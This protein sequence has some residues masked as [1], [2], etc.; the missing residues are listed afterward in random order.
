MHHLHKHLADA[1]RILRGLPIPPE[2]HN[3]YLANERILIQELLDELQQHPVDT[4][5]VQRL[6]EKLAEEARD[7]SRLRTGVD[8]FLNEYSLSSD[9]GIV[10]MCLAE[11]LIRIPDDATAIRLIQDRLDDGDWQ[12]HLGQSDSM[13]VNASTWG[14][15]LTGRLFLNTDAAS[16]FSG[17]SRVASRLGKEIALKTIR[18]A[19]SIVGQQFVISE[20]I[21]DTLRTVGPYQPQDTGQGE[22]RYSFDM[23]G[24]AAL[25]E[26]DASGYLQSY[27]D[28]IE[29]LGSHYGDAPT[30]VAAISIKL[31]ALHPRFEPRHVDALRGV[32]VERVQVLLEAARALDIQV[33]VDAEEAHRHHLTLSVFHD[34]YTSPQMKGWD[35]LG[36]AVQTYQKRAPATLRWIAELAQRERRSIPVRLVKGAYWDTEVKRAQELGLSDYPVFVRKQATDVAYLACAH[37]ILQSD[38][39]LYGQFATHNAQTLASVIEFARHHE[40][41]QFEV[42]RL[43]GMGEVLCEV[44]REVHPQVSQRIYAPVGPYRELLPYLMRRLLENGANSSFVHHLND[45]RMPI[46]ELI[47]DPAQELEDGRYVSADVYPPATL[48]GP[49]RVNSA[50]INLDD[51]VTLSEVLEALESDLTPRQEIQSL[52]HAAV[53]DGDT[54]P[55]PIINPADTDHVLGHV[56]FAGATTVDS[57]MATATAAFDS[58]RQVGVGTRAGMLE[59]LANALEQERSLLLGLLTCEAGKTLTAAQAEIREAVDFCRYYAHLARE[60][61]GTPLQLPGPTGEQNT[62]HYEP[63]GPFLCIAPWNFPLAIFT[64]QLAAALVTGN[65]VIAKPSEFTGLIAS[66]LVQLA[67]RAGFPEQ[68]LSLLLAHGAD[69]LPL[70]TDSRLAGVSFTG[71]TATARTIQHALAERDGGFIP[72][73]AETG[74]LNA[75]I[76]DSSA[77]PEQVVR[78]VIESA[79]DCAGQRCSALRVLFVQEDIADAILDSLKGAMATLMVGHPAALDTDIGPVISAA[80]ATELEDYLNKFPSAS[81]MRSPLHDTAHG[82]YVAPAI[83]ELDEL[84]MPEREVFGPVLHV[85]RFAASGLDK[86]VALVRDSGFA[87]T[88]G[89]HSRIQGRA[90]RIA[91]AVPVGNFYVNRTTIGATVESQPFGGFGLSG[92]GPKA[93]GPNYL[94]AFCVERTLTINTAAVGGDAQLLGGPLRD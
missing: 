86:V 4:N 16:F 51:P 64:G 54:P 62:L 40:N 84:T 21:T 45:E 49:G 59:A 10:L 70:L 68:V 52:I 22:T 85:S 2:L 73:I 74:G 36:L 30:G 65:T 8:T 76:A 80:R 57:A 60:Q 66:Q 34:L 75:M 71:S 17:V 88:L 19:M 79:F 90:Q 58:W 38:G 29:A 83:I 41:D 7:R 91:S 53:S 23:L 93:G 12:T 63:R 77:H 14:L 61:L 94:K 43:F 15:L 32:L 92:I 81:V 27:L 11:A 67:H 9:E 56:R 26:D 37:R 50:G 47:R 69:T 44:L 6:A 20:T 89:L 55:Q 82:H 28:A 1:Q 78:D 31:S 13:L 33:T 42:Q 39:A 25:S 5:D 18:Q 72:L 87:L 46:Y 24:E 48:Y 35:G 3:D